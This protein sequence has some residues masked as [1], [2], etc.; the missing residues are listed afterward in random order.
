MKRK[1]NKRGSV[2]VCRLQIQ[3][4]SFTHIKKQI[5]K[6]RKAVQVCIISLTTAVKK[7]ALNDNATLDRPRQTSMD[8]NRTEGRKL[9]NTQKKHGNAE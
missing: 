4:E 1:K 3:G 7:D 8:N 2:S 6:R 9:R 5:K